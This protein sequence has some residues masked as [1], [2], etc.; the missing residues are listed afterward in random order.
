[1]IQLDKI[2]VF[3]LEVRLKLTP[4]WHFRNNTLLYYI[5]NAKTQLVNTQKSPYFK[6]YYYTFE[7]LYQYVDIVKVVKK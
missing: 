4:S 2:S 7:S 1:M 6:A 5:G 3:E